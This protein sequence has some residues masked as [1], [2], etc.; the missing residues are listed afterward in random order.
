MA[1]R[2]FIERTGGIVT[3]RGGGNLSYFDNGVFL[4]ICLL[5]LSCALCFELRSEVL[6][7]FK[8]ASMVFL[9]TRLLLMP[10]RYG[11]QS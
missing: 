6:S 9:A 11:S 4:T 5:A 7:L 8:L 2:T 3:V 1:F 10:I